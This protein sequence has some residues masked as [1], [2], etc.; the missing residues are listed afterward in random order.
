M[1]RVSFAVGF[2]AGFVAGAR[3]GRD[4]YDQIVKV[5]RNTAEHPAVQQAA[6]TV[7]EQATNLFNST[8]QKVGGQLHDKVPQM[9]HSVGDRIPGMK[10]RNGHGDQ[11]GDTMS[12]DNARTF[13]TSG[14]N[15]AKPGKPDGGNIVR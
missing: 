5:A 10:H 14:S 15:Q 13:A 6:G 7:Q 11:A 2:A 3:A 12:S 9:A 4:K 8:S 1:N